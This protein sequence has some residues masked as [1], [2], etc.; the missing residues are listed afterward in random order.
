MGKA[1]ASRR[2]FLRQSGKLFGGSWAAI[3]APLILAAVDVALARQAR[4]ASWTTLS[5]GGAATLGAIADQIFPADETP[6]AVELGSVY[7]MDVALGG[8]MSGSLSTIRAG[9][10]DLDRRA[11]ASGHGAFVELDAAAQIRLLK[12]IESTP[13]FVTTHFLVLCGVFSSPAYGGNLDQG[14]WKLLG[15]EPRHVWQPPFGYYDAQHG[16]ESDH[17]GS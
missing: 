3:N 1:K 14:G 8:F 12:E 2:D 13:F 5:E 9:C 11:A 4:G 7:F 16:E 10:A 15:F 17:A 6:G